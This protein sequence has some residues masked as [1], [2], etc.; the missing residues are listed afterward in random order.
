MLWCPNGDSIGPIHLLSS[1]FIKCELKSLPNSL[2]IFF[3]LTSTKFLPKKKGSELIG[4]LFDK[5]LKAC[6]DLS[7]EVFQGCVDQRTAEL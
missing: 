2:L 6:D 3:I 5:S 4:I 1:T 7:K